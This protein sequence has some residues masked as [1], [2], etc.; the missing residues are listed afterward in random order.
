M[1]LQ[2]FITFISVKRQPVREYNPSS[3]SLIGINNHRNCDIY[4]APGTEYEF[5]FKNQCDKRR[6]IDIY[7]DGTKVVDSLIIGRWQQLYLERFFDTDKKF[8]TAVKGDSR[9]SDPTSKDIGKI[10]IEVYK[11]NTPDYIEP[12]VKTSG[13]AYLGDHPS[14]KKRMR[15]GIPPRMRNGSSGILRGADLGSSADYQAPTSMVYSCQ[16]NDPVL[17]FNSP[18]EQEVI[19]PSSLPS[20]LAT[21][22]GSKSNQ[23]LISV[24]WEGDDIKSLQVFNYNLLEKNAEL[25]NLT[26]KFCT[27]CGNKSELNHKFCAKCGKKF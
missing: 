19:A 7:I 20:N 23:K 26:H 25:Q 21:I 11:E 3:S 15:G 8:M 18:V 1:H 22:E 9:V 14:N 4:L 27:S 24:T 13:G 17:G 2:D 6:R 16:V 12:A 5:G 10:R